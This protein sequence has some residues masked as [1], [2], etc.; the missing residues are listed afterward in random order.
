MLVKYL[1][2]K[3]ILILF[4][5]LY[6]NIVTGNNFNLIICLIDWLVLLKRKKKDMKFKL[7]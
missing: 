6:K 5:Q 7:E 1:Y 2:D 4:D 3:L